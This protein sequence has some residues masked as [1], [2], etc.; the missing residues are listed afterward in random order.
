MDKEMLQNIILNLEEDILKEKATFGIYQFGGGPDESCIKA[1]EGG[2]KLFAITLLK[3]AIE[4]KDKRNST[5]K[6]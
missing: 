3:A 2:L 6:K 5:I 4:L 1:D